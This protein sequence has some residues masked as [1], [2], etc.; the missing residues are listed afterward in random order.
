MNMNTGQ[1]TISTLPPTAT[2]Q[3]NANPQAIPALTLQPVSGGTDQS[4]L[5]AGN[6][7]GN[8]EVVGV[9]EPVTALAPPPH[10]TFLTTS[11]IVL[12]FV[13]LAVGLRLLNM[14]NKP[15]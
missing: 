13:L 2:A 8:L 15:A 12:T 14:S 11:L 3:E 7:T 4:T 10:N 9:R 1:E 6:G 5:Q